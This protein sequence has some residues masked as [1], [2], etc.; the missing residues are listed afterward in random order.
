MRENY[1]KG[2]YAITML[3]NDPFFV[4]AYYTF[5]SLENPLEEVKA[6]KDYLSKLDATSRIYISEEGIN[7]QLSASRE[8]ALQYIDWMHSRRPFR[9]LEFKIHGWHE[10]AFPR[11]TIKYRKHLVARDRT[12]DITKQGAHVAPSD[13]EKMLVEEKE[14]LLLDVR[15]DYEWKVGRF[16]G[17][18]L[19]PCETFRDFEK[20]A[21]D[22]KEKCD[23]KTK[24]VMMYCT[25][26]I[27]CE[28]YSALLKDLGFEH[29]YQLQGGI[30]KYGLEQGNKHWLGKLYV[31]DD[32]MTVPI[33]PEE[34]PVIGTCHHCA[35]PIESYYNCASMDCNTL[36]LA[37]PTCVEKF[38]GC[39][40]P[41]CQE[42]SRLRPY[43]HQNPHKPFRKKHHYN[44][45]TL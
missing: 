11:L 43:Q 7:G 35:T 34:T 2:V 18:E 15:N 26:G 19:P 5:Q 4:L 24:K 42:S 25:G 31:F 12:V 29:V 10:Q 45:C 39:C 41:T 44:T 36:F 38:Q 6:H 23:P 37:C 20:Y 33:S 28:V 16:Q 8:H 40:A 13:W 32:R 30:I 21:E 14:A 22:L 9:Q 3:T 1:W 17:A 27:R